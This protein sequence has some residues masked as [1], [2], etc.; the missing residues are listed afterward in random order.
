[1]SNMLN[2]ELYNQYYITN[3]LRK[4]PVLEKQQN[5]EENKI[6]T[7]GKRITE[8]KSQIDK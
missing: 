4:L 1:M 5:E 6:S 7:Y 3:A 2:Q 8:L